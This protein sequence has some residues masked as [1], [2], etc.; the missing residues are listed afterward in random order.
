MRN[1]VHVNF[2]GHDPPQYRTYHRNG[3]RINAG[4]LL[5]LFLDVSVPN[6]S[7]AF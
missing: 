4:T 7:F 6:I 2:D 5:V 3:V 1:N